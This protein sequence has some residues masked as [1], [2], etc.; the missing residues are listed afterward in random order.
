MYTSTS[1]LSTLVLADT[2]CWPDLFFNSCCNCWFCGLDSLLALSWLYASTPLLLWMFT[3]THASPLFNVPILLT[4]LSLAKISL[5]VLYVSVFL[6]PW[7]WWY[8]ISQAK[9]GQPCLVLRG[10]TLN[11]CHYPL[12][13][14]GEGAALCVAGIL[15]FD[16]Q[17]GKHY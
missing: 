3:I 10:K 17:I 9:Q 11:K 13:S 4:S 15:L 2:H 8:Q 6:L 7:L 14:T 16:L 12:G 1:T 5:Y